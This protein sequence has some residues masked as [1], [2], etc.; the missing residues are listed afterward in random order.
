MKQAFGRLDEVCLQM[1]F[2]LM[3]FMSK[4]LDEDLDRGSMIMICRCSG[5]PRLVKQVFVCFEAGR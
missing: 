5:G 1:T 2:T 3:R 4:T